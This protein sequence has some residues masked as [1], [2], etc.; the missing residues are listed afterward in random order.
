MSLPKDLTDFVHDALK[1][2]QSRDAIRAHLL[3]AEWTETEADAALAGWSETATSTGPVP[4]PI[5]STAAR[6]AFFYAL[7]FVAFGMV[8]GNVLTL[9][10]GQIQVWLPETGRTPTYAASGLRWSMA[11]LI[12]FAPAFWLLDR[13][14]AR[15]LRGDPSRRHGTIRR[16]LS[17]L[18]MLIAVITL[19]GDALVLIYTFLDG[20]MTAR[21]LAKSL[22]VAVIA[23]VV[24]AYFRQDRSIAARLIPGLPAAAL[25]GLAALA[26]GLSFWIVGGPLQGQMEQRDR[27]RLSDLR[28]LTQDVRYCA[29][30][31]HDALPE[32]LDP[33]S[34]ARNPQ[35]LTA[36]AAEITY[37]RIDPTRFE[38][39][40]EVEFPTAIS[41]YDI[42]LRDKN[43]CIV[44]DT[45]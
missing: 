20:Q 33:L 12:V 43:A 9:F 18:A 30:V 25:L 27:W 16:W 35:N 39:C 1:S 37:R 38:L 32:T 6:D 34:C 10:F 44:V 8:A 26:L 2:G 28:T 42:T 7:L 31:D 24:L 29:E 11:A 3:A 36:F 5:R 22:T 13:A 4:R 21:F 19:M 41:R 40:T 15:A 14:D 45:D 23:T 17:S